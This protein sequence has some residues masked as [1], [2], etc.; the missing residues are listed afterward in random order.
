MTLDSIDSTLFNRFSAFSSP[1]SPLLRIPLWYHREPE[2][3]WRICFAVPEK[4]GVN[5]RGQWDLHLAER[6]CE[7]SRSRRSR[8]H[9][10]SNRACITPIYTVIT[11]CLIP[12]AGL[13]SRVAMPLN[14]MLIGVNPLCSAAVLQS[15]HSSHRINSEPS[16]TD[17]D[18]H[19]PAPS[20]AVH[21]PI[22]SC[23][24]RFHR[25]ARYSPP[26]R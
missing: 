4:Q 13:I 18:S 1:S 15:N 14:S 6:L 11:A 9:Q 16:R 20:A 2:L 23:P 22:P 26:W 7:I 17:R 24:F 25:P 21:L 8:E 5:R 3:V 12:D 19:S 10:E